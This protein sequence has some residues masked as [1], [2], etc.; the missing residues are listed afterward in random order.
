MPRAVALAFV[1]VCLVLAIAG[2]PSAAAGSA[3][4]TS[5]ALL[6][7]TNLARQAHG[8]PPYRASR[9][10]KRSSRRYARRMVRG[11]FFAH[12]ARLP[13]S[14]RYRSRAEVLHWSTRGGAAA[15]VR[16]WLN[17]PVHRGILLS[18]QFREAGFGRARGTI[19]AGGPRGS[20]WVG[21][22]G[23]R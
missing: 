4:R 2:S 17:S 3:S 21:H 18:R 22:L 15:A 11:N 20:V 23:R 5:A 10:L 14:H 7:Q 16:A 9:S 19:R 12:L 13:I 6:H 8:L 1:L